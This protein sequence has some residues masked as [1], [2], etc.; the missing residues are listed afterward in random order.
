MER[1]SLCLTFRIEYQEI[2]GIGVE[3][4]GGCICDEADVGVKYR[5]ALGYRKHL[6]P[7]S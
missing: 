3:Y 5:I 1:C 7:N 2:E 6:I 4:Q